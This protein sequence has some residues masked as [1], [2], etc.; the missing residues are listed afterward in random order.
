MQNLIGK[1]IGG[2]G[3]IVVAD[4]PLG[5]GGEGSVFEVQSH[6][7]PQLPPAEELVVKL[8]HEPA[9]RRAKI[10]AM[11]ENPPH[12]SSV[13]WPVAIVFNARKEFVGYA[14]KKLADSGYQPWAVLAHS[15]ERKKIAPAFDVRYALTAAR[16][17]A[18]AIHSVHL[19][20]HRVGDVNESNIFVSSNAQVLL[21][22]TDSAQISTPG[23]AFFPCL[24]GK[25]EYTAP[26]LSRGSLRDQKRTAESDTF[27]F[28][29]AVYQMMTG[30]AH[31]TDGVFRGD[32]EP[33]STVDKIRMGVLPGLGDSSGDLSP[34]PRIPVEG[35]PSQLRNAVRRSLAV[36]PAQRLSLSEFAD[37]FD[38]VLSRVVQCSRVPQHWYDPQDGDCGWCA[39]VA[40]GQLDPWANTPR[41]APQQKALPQVPFGSAA[42]PAPARRA[43][44]RLPAMQSPQH[45]G[46]G[47]L[48]TPLPAPSSP[49]GAP[50]GPALSP[51]NAQQTPP[52]TSSGPPPASSYRGR[53]T[54]LRYPDGS[55]RPRPPL[56][57]LMRSNKKLAFSCF[58]NEIPDLLK[59]WWPHERKAPDVFALVLGLALG[60]S[61]AMTWSQHL[62]RL[63]ASYELSSPILDRAI[64]YGSSAAAVGALFTTLA[65][66]T[67]GTLAYVQGARG[68]TQKSGNE[69]MGRTL[70]RF[71]ACAV[72]YGPLLVLI[73]T[74]LAIYW[75]LVF[76]A[77][78]VRANR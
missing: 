18:V 15:G 21:V 13:A 54:L 24:V 55:L 64:F 25:P 37:V 40:K 30:G 70:L 48:P 2:A 67:F 33:P 50:A 49:P 35:I 28:G 10:I 46:P 43:P 20:G 73:A 27:A 76:L 59:F 56:A 63:M 23:G 39:H 22:D 16:N 3:A 29:V 6:S 26:E 47:A 69:F 77:A 17:L 75:T 65:L 41:P 19:A 32:G 61:L 62:P 52:Q 53:K 5:R 11:L 38:A 58:V 45:A 34:A 4:Q 68:S 51:L 7:I 60:L 74:G 78:V 72:F 31:P 57:L 1:G 14:M 42:P 71:G 36:D 44:M 12:D 8:Y 66:A 9:D